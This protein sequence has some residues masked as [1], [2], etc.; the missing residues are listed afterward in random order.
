[1][2]RQRILLLEHDGALE[3]VL[4]DLFED[5]DLDVTLCGSLADLQAG[6]KQYPFAVVVSDS[7]ERDDYAKLSS[8][9]RAE[10]VALAETA[11]VVLTTGRT[12]PRHTQKD[13][14]RGVEIVEKPFD[15]DRLMTAARA[16]LERA[17]GRPGGRRSTAEQLQPRDR[18]EH[19]KLLGQDALG[20]ERTVVGLA[21]AQIWRHS[22]CKHVLMWRGNSVGGVLS[23]PGPVVATR[24]GLGRRHAS[25]VCNA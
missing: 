2:V 19:C 1:M 23:N 12:W 16:A 6:V 21:S 24:I 11:E 4:C 9:H 14:L 3:A 22:E 10:I 18:C 20:A 7:W 8:Q 13:E 17:A 5:E 25:Q 15:L